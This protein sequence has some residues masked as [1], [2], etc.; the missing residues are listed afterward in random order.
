VQFP[1]FYQILVAL[2]AIL[3]VQHVKALLITAAY[4]AMVQLMCLH[5]APA[6]VVLLFAKFAHPI[7]AAFVF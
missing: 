5:R 7:A 4:L 6:M 2:N 1:T 3:L